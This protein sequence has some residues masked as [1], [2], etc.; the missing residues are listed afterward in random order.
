MH[1]PSADK[2]SVTTT[3]HLL[4]QGH[5]AQKQLFS[6]NAIV[7]WS[8]RRRFALARELATAGAGGALLDY[9]CGDGT[10]IA[11]AH[12][13]FR[14]T[15]GTDVD[16]EQ[17][18]DCGRRLSSV[19]D[20]RFASLDEL[21]QSAYAGHF[22]AVMCMEVL[23][24]CPSD[25]QPQVLADLARLV[26]SHGVVIISVPI[27]IG[28]TLVLK[29]AVRATAAATGLVEYEDRER[30]RISEFMRMLLARST[31]QIERRA[32]ISINAHGDTVRYHGHKGFNWRVLARVIESIFVIERRLYSPIPLTGPWLNSQVWFVCRKR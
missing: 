8:H 10:F 9:G 29:Q 13:L 25:V 12:D 31:S 17:L 28:P 6:K 30:Y 23:E 21:R 1:S 11:L 27:E 4:E 2:S 26:R 20:V 3:S 14:E 32:T 5:Y 15:T 7:A 16:V 24:H 22:D 18:H 19:S